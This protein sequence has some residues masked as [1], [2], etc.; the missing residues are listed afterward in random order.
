MVT[1]NSSES[2]IMLTIRLLAFFISAS[3]VAGCA[4]G[5]DYRKPDIAL[6][7]QFM[8][9]TQLENR[10]AVSNATLA[11]WWFRERLAGPRRRL[12]GWLWRPAIEPFRPAGTR[13]KPGYG[14]GF[15]THSASTVRLGK[16]RS[17]V[18]PFG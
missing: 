14:A 2:P 4:V 12:V 15:R 6:A 5:P 9:Q 3:V 7:D 8:G 1:V 11:A 16:R 18:T 13:T 10:S 17:S